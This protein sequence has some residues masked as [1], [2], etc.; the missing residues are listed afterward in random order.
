MFKFNS[1]AAVIQTQK[2]RVDT[3]VGWDREAGT[4]TCHY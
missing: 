3:R 1:E 2:K 4:C